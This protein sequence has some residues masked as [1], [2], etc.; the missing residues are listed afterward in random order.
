MKKRRR[1]LIFVTG[2]F[3]TLGVSVPR[4]NAQSDRGTITGT[5]TDSSGAVIVGA[6]VTATHVATNTSSKVTTGGNG[7]FT[8]PLLRVGEYLLT[9]QKAGFKQY[10]GSDITVELGQTAHV[11]IRLEVGLVT[12]SITVSSEV[13]MVE[14]AT[15]DRGTI[16]SGT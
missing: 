7:G 8:F 9:A 10:V 1:A 4:L 11:D 16:I 12:E 3:L 14:S 5:V 6:G 13:L 2:L 15:S